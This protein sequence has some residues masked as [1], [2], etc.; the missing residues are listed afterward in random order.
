M[1]PFRG[2]NSVEGKLVLRTILLTADHSL[3]WRHE[4]RIL[5]PD[6]V[7]GMNKFQITSR[8]QTAGID[9]CDAIVPPSRTVFWTPM[10]LN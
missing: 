8:H 6:V 3:P 10:M 2:C 4:P 1:S 9:C 5:L 7:S